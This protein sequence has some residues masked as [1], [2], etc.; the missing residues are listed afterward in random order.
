[1]SVPD[2]LGTQGTFLLFTTRPAGERFKEG[3]IRIAVTIQGD[4]I[5]TAV[6]GPENP[7]AADARPLERAAA[8]SCSIGPGSEVEVD[9]GGTRVDAHARTA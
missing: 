2:L 8:A 9:A 5:D 6:E 7:F 3:G 1:M 4:R